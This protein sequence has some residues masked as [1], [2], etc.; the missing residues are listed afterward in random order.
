MPLSRLGEAEP[1]GKNRNLLFKRC[2]GEQ[3][4]PSLSGVWSERCLLPPALLGQGSGRPWALTAMRRCRTDGSP[5]LQDDAGPVEELQELLEK[6]NFELSQAR[7]RLVTLTATV[8][9]L[10]EDLGTARR[11][12]VRSEELSGRHQR[13]LREVSKGRVVLGAGIQLLGGQLP[14]CP[15]VGGGLGPP[16]P[17]R[18]GLTLG[19]AHSGREGWGEVGLWRAAWR[20]HSLPGAGGRGRWEGAGRS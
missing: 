19:R 14:G 9:E 10:E 7:E 6:Q 12:L 11:D 17:G 16:G 4:R 20:R 18:V 3:G 15:G 1:A 2:T 13:D 8:A 5:S